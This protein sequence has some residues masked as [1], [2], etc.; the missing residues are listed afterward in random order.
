[1]PRAIDIV[2]FDAA[3]PVEPPTLGGKCRNLAALTRAGLPVPP[4]FAI[5]AETFDAFVAFAGLHDALTAAGPPELQGDSELVDRLASAE[6]PPVIH[7]AMVG[8]YRE[9]GRRMGVDAP[10]VAVRSSATTEDIEAATAAGQQLTILN[11]CGADELIEAIKRCWA[12]LYSAHAVAYRGARGL[13]RGYASIA[14]GVQAL[15]QARSSGVLFTADPVTGDDS[16]M[17]IEAI[18]GLG[19]PLV[20]GEIT[21][22]RY[23][24]DKK[25]GRVLEQRIGD[26]AFE[27]VGSTHGTTRRDI[28][29]ERR[30]L[31][32]LD[33]DNLEQLRRL[34]FQVE[35][36]LGVNQ[37]IEWAV[38]DAS[39][40]FLLQAR[41][42]TAGLTP[43]LAPPAPAA[44]PASGL[45]G[46][47]Y[48]RWPGA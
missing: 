20:G 13:D 48:R 30:R 2:W 32:C 18:W 27:L 7:S 16:H 47:L 12:S 26:K 1:M 29:T 21:P 31:P 15:V 24:I 40:S 10:R 43:Q 17:V 36:A 5:P 19:E 42:I 14:V 3:G 44:R 41:P 25:S 23:V 33:H 8:A 6:I 38:D 45:M 37:D 46:E 22:D 4:G 9:L 11:V 34:A 39:R 35:A 28:T